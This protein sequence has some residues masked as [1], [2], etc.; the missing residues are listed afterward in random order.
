MLTAF[1]P[2]PVSA[3]TIDDLKS[4]FPYLKLDIEYFK[5]R[6]LFSAQQRK[7]ESEDSLFPAGGKS[8]EDGLKSS[9]PARGGDSEII[10]NGAAAKFSDVPS[11]AWFSKYVLEMAQSGV[12]SGYTDGEG[13]LTG[14][15]GPDDPVTLEQLAKI[16]LEAVGAQRKE[17]RGEI[18]NKTAKNRWSEKYVLCAES[19]G[20]A[21][22]SDGSVDVT[23]SARRGEGAVTVLQAFGV[24]FKEISGKVFTDVSA[25]VEFA[26]AIETAA[27]DGL[28]S[29]YMD[30]M[31]VLTGKFGPSDP[32]KRAEI[33]KI[34][35]VARKIYQRS[36]A[37][38]Q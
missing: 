2:S 20:W 10:S 13:R 16:V 32:V 24:K 37:V 33:A 11:G 34:V 31:G 7:I 36:S 38:A 9:A 28:V 26:S 5:S 14:L 29:G 27:R 8:G 25:S 1:A 3:G 4:D 18:R 23:R 21:V 30:E 22:F 17:C 6:D 15:F 12:V 35:S 19:L